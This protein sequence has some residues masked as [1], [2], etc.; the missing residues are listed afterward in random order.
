LRNA[1]IAALEI[2]EN[3]DWINF[4][5]FRRVDGLLEH[6]SWFN[7][8]SFLCHFCDDAATIFKAG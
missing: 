5:I 7:G 4:S 3:H 6:V 1:P 2:L 8:V